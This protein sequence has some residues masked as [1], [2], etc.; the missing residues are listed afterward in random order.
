[1]ELPQEV[2]QELIE[3]IEQ[4][5]SARTVIG[6]SPIDVRYKDVVHAFLS[7]PEQRVRVRVRS[8]KKEFKEFCKRHNL[9][10][11]VI[12]AKNRDQELVRWRKLFMASVASAYS[13]KKIAQVLN[14]ERSTI[15]GYLKQMAEA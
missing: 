2:L 1:M 5:R 6:S 9:I 12:K 10:P 13:H 4:K 14:M 3:G 8:I 7:N 15:S 11:R